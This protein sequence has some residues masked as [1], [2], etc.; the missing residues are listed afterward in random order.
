MSPP[1]EEIQARLETHF[2][3]LSQQRVQSQLPVFVLEHGL[4][5]DECNQIADALR[6]RV[7]WGLKL[8][9][10]WLLW[11]VHIT[12][13]GYAYEGDEFWRSFE[14]Q[15][16]G[17][18]FQHRASVSGWFKKFQNAYR[19]VVPSGAWAQHFSIIAWPITHAIL[20]RYLQL[21]F[22][23]ALF[24]LRYDLA[25]I[26]RGDPQSIGQLL[27]A[28]QSH[29]S[30]RFAAFLEQE[31]L[32][33]RI[34]LALLKEHPSGTEAPIYFPTLTR[35][36]ENLE[37]VRSAKHW[38]NETRRI[39]KERF[40]GLGHTSASSS[41]TAGSEAK[42]RSAEGST[43]T[44]LCP[45]LVLRHLGAGKW[46][47]NMQIPNFRPIAMLSAD[48]G[49]FLQRT[50]CRINGAPDVKPG[51]W[52]LGPNR[53]AVIKQ[54]PQL[55][56]PLINFEQR[57]PLLEQMMAHEAKLSNE[58]AW[59]FRCGPDGLAYHITS[60]VLRPG[61][62]YLLVARDGTI[63]P[64]IPGLR[65]CHLDCAGAFGVRFEVPANAPAATI[66]QL[67]SLG[68]EI[69]RTVRIWP[70]GVPARAW[71]GQGRSEWLTTD[72]PCLGI[73]SDFPVSAYGLRLD[74]RAEIPITVS[75]PTEPV[76]IELGPLSAGPHSLIVC[77]YH[78]AGGSLPTQE[79]HLVLNVRSPEPW[80]PGVSG[81]TGLIATL[82]PPNTDLDALWQ[83]K[84]KLSAVGPASHTVTCR[85][86]LQRADGSQ[87]LS[88][89]VVDRAELPLTHS[90]WNR[91]FTSFVA[92]P[93]VGWAY[94]EAAVCLLTVESEELGRYTMRFE[95]A[96]AP[97]RWVAR[98]SHGSIVLRLLDDTGMDVS[99]IELSHFGL[100]RPFLR[101]TLQPSA[102]LSGQPVLPPGGLYIARHGEHTDQLLISAIDKPKGFDSLGLNPNILELRSG[103]VSTAQAA[104]SLQ[105]WS[106]T[107]ALGQLV[108]LRQL[109][110]VETICQGIVDCICGQDWSDA[111]RAF[112]H[113]PASSHSLSLLKQRVD[114]R[115][116]L[117]V[118]L[119][120]DFANA[121]LDSAHRVAW[122]QQ[123]ASRYG[124]A[125]DK[126]LCEF[127]L[128][129]ASDPE[130]LP[131]VYGE[132]LSG[133]YARLAA[134]PVLFRAARLIA[135]LSSQRDGVIPIALFPR[136]QW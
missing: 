128:R 15:T 25:Q 111:E 80:I 52:L 13:R 55:Q 6:Y 56:Q 106:Q 75:T 43:R 32:A 37:Q 97:L 26:E 109:Q 50:R 7:K 19:G 88:A 44:D 66:A 127:T 110:V 102:F 87:I 119:V 17:W 4:S 42:A 12:E 120:R 40:R 65:P 129:A 30:T 51:G 58:L 132:R 1:L 133:L 99:G 134:N 35:I 63:L 92:R 45:V 5:Q 113:V 122:F 84:L 10:Q 73:A 118:V 2:A 117:A 46:G 131:V 14:E 49:A 126:E 60:R 77:A 85:I 54:W 68:I 72:R 71:D 89:A 114:V 91:H 83:H 123:T 47:L 78:G 101:Q 59:I 103:A 79:G 105:Q 86:S 107:R 28:T 8:S 24:E 64:P 100:E 95:R 23:R 67:K 82:D 41:T 48:I 108:S 93:E 9:P 136:W 22:A 112:R 135:L 39:V 76:Y 94:L 96:V 69:A 33:G 124:V 53:I 104:Q 21:Q 74:G 81:H 61:I 125:C 18:T 98:Q 116:S 36:V 16:P 115:P 38:F 70:A 90:Q 20:P 121:E 31:E 27:A 11:I 3:T 34:V 62:S 57:H 29:H 130:A